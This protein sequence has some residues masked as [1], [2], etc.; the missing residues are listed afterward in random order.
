MTSET[1]KSCPFCGGEA[2]IEKYCDECSVEINFECRYD[3]EPNA[4][5]SLG[6]KVFWVEHDCTGIDGEN[7]GTIGTGCYASAAEAIAAWNARYHCGLTDEDYNILL[8]ELGVSE[9]TCQDSGLVL[10]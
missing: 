4:I 5:C 8:D 6:E 7:W 1:L 2:H 10:K 3:K 9:R